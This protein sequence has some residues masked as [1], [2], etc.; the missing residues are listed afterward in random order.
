MSNKLNRRN[1][2][3]TTASA[4]V[5]FWLAGRGIARARSVSPN[6]KLNIAM[7]GC[8]GRA[9][10]NI[11]G[12]KSENIVAVCDVHANLLGELADRFPKAKKFRDYRKMFD[13]CHRQI[14][15]V[16]VST[17]D[18]SHALPS[19][20]AMRLGKHVY[21]EKPLAWSVEEVRLMAAEA[22]K[23]KVATQMGTQGMAMDSARAGIEMLRTGVLGDIRELHVWTDRAG[24][25]W[26]QGVDRPTET[27]PAP[28]ALDWD[29]WLGGAP[30]RPYNPIYTPFKWRGW[31]DF[32]T[33]PIGDM[34]VHNAA[35]PLTALQL[36]PPRSVEIVGTSGLKSE[37]YPAWAKLRCEF[38]ARDGQ[39]PAVL[40]WYDGGQLPPKNLVEGELQDNGAIVVGSKGT[41]CSYKWTGGEWDL[42]PK[43]KFQDL[44]VPPPSIARAP[45][46]DIYQEWI[47]AC[48]GGRLPF[49]N[50]TD[51][52]A[53]LT[54]VM[55]VN[56]LALHV[57]K[58]IRWNAD[59]MEAEDCPEAD[60]FVR[61]R[62]RKGWAITA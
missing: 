16:V 39:K 23:H 12:V 34:G 8:G 55:L 5:G 44:K 35:M 47:D 6:E 41:L 25:R 62:Y 57:G 11:E 4:G 14:D 45:R 21:C 28:K 31:K 20:I 59:R 36:G 48:K 46:Q 15:A 37:T 13:D 50:F 19:L 61:R 18:H 27:P 60:G 56:A 26:P 30:V 29:L 2:L 32:S 49:C 53:P 43:Q 22:A 3:R 24:K 9:T 33:G 42:F 10:V 17:P 51:Y 40:Y 38:A 58:N 1:M 7:I 52:A 54:E